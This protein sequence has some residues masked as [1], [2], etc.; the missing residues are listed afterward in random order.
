MWS[1]PSVDTLPGP[2]LKASPI[3]FWFLFSSS[4]SCLFSTLRGFLNTLCAFG[5]S[6]VSNSLILLVTPPTNSCSGFSPSTLLS[7][8]NS[9]SSSLNTPAFGRFSIFLP[10]LISNPL[11]FD[12]SASSASSALLPPSSFS[13]IILW[14]PSLSPGSFVSTSSPPPSTPPSAPPPSELTLSAIDSPVPF[15]S[16]FVP[17]TGFFFFFLSFFIF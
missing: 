8:P 4:D 13:F 11:I 6:T 16:L 5:A 3:N 9:Q 1:S 12:F 10:V 14:S 7:L 17:P 2:I 15:S